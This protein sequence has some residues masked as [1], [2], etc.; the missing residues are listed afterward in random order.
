MW[1]IKTMTKVILDILSNGIALWTPADI[2]SVV[3]PGQKAYL[4]GKMVYLIVVYFLY[5]N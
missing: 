1:R 2:N 4:S 5:T 3:I